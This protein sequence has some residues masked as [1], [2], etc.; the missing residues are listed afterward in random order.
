MDLTPP[1]R[2]A[3]PVAKRLVTNM[4]F[5][6]SRGSRS[7]TPD[8]FFF[9]PKKRGKI[10]AL[11]CIWGMRGMLKCRYLTI[12]CFLTQVDSFWDGGDLVN[13]RRC[14]PHI[15]LL[16]FRLRKCVEGAAEWNGGIDYP[17]GARFVHRRSLAGYQHLGRPLNWQHGPSLLPSAQSCRRLWIHFKV[18]WRVFQPIWMVG[19]WVEWKASWLMRNKRLN[20]D[21]SSGSR[22]LASRPR[23]KFE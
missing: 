14:Y 4:W 11:I 23:A 16:P 1:T 10:S 6:Q 5:S 22:L 15:L 9:L 17:V 20:D 21:G 18:D 12:E 2:L 3:P 13:S 7:L 19:K 8:I